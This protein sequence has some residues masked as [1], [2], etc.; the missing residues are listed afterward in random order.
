MRRQLTTSVT[1]IVLFTA[2]LGVVYPLAVTGVAQV[3]FP[4]RANGSTVTRDGRVVGSSLLAQDF[5]GER[6]YF[7][8]RPS[9]TGYSPAATAFANLGPNGAA[10]RDATRRHLAAYLRRERPFDPALT[11]AG[12]PVDAVTFSASGV[13]PHISEANAA[14]QAH[15]VAAVRRLPLA[16]VRRLIADHTDGRSLGLLGEPG[17][18]VTELNLALDREAPTR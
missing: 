6:R 9:V 15:R 17:V 11:P 2:L 5:R 16:R 18:N 14:I 10:T 4:H 3:A 12:V 1:A 7:Q 13:D 8:P